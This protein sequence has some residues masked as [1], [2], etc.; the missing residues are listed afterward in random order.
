[1]KI[2][3]T[4]NT[5]AS[6]LK[7]IVFGESG[8]GKTTLAGTIN[9][10]TLIISAESG[11]LSLANKKIDVVDI[12]IDD[13][14][15][16]IPKEKR[17]ARLGEVYQY[18]VTE[19]ARKKYKWVFIDSLSEINQNMLEQLN[20]EFPER[21]DSLVMYGELSKRMRSMVK[22]FRDLPYYNVVFTALSDF[23]KDENGQRFIGIS[24]V[25]NF[26]NKIAAFFDEVFYLHVERDADGNTKRVLV[27]E[28]SDKLVAKDR[29][30]KLSKFEEP[31]LQMI[32]N[33][34]KQTKKEKEN[35]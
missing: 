31:N 32:A 20:T 28:K 33:K 18:L 10:P 21:K 12:S 27:T 2:S 3:S 11:L 22:T 23:D 4:A 13:N 14:G 26:S 5:G 30:G 9:E 1:M 6:I 35:V 24:L 34:I 8:A 17:I 25:G 29:S 19:E 16:V 15:D 7:M